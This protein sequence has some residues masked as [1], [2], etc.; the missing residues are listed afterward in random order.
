MFSFRQVVRALTDLFFGACYRF[1]RVFIVWPIELLMRLWFHLDPRVYWERSR[2]RHLTEGRIARKG[3]RFVLLVVYGRESLP[4]FTRSLVDAVNR[5]G[6][7]LVVSTNARIE[8][9]LRSE[10]L[11]CC[12]L[13]IERADL[14]RDF[15]GY[16]DGMSLIEKRFGLPSRL[17]LMND[18]LFYFGQGVD[19]LVAALDSEDDLIAMCEDAYQYYHLQ[20]FALSFS[21]KVLRNRLFRAFWRK[22]RPISTRFW[23]IHRGERGLTRCV[24]R[25]GMK[26]RVIYSAAQLLPHL[27]ACGFADLLNA[28][29]LLPWLVREPLYRQLNEVRQTRTTAPIPMLD[30]LS[31]G[32]RH[33]HRMKGGE[34][35]ELR[36]AN[37]QGMLSISHQ[38]L[39]AHEQ[40]EEWA[41]HSIGEKIVTLVA[42]RNQIHF[43][44]FLFM[45][46]LGMPAFKRDL[47]FREV[48][49]L[50]EIDEQLSALPV[51]SRSEILADIRQKG[52]VK[53]FTG[54]P[55]LLYSH[56]A[57]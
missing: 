28:V 55:R 36:S 9:S 45:K 7:N 6:L 17:I 40:L 22:Y 38:S 18:S 33:L 57:I 12:C 14:G 29:R 4:K 50:E 42:D 47:F 43:G 23:A 27:R 39:A 32:M 31:R 5:R 15:G 48:Y 2:I 44:G 21:G 19:S 51:S 49:S 35:K 8:P 52:T 3:D 56:G 26:P 11:E 37:V 34:A 16:K 54:L 53:F 10:L 30:T 25:A 20:S 1:E 13:L 46:Y 41:S 24:L